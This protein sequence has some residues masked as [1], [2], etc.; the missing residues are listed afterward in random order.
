MIAPFHPLQLTLGL[1]VWSV[2]FVALY[3]GLSVACA[4]APPAATLGA[5]TWINGLLLLLTL[6]TTALLAYWAHGCWRAAG[7]EVGGQ[8][9]D[10][11]E[12]RDNRARLVERVGGV[13]RK[14]IG[15]AR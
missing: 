2:W 6:A 7:G 10:R 9:L 14:V 15:D 5:L 8:V 13:F 3:G 1:I 11:V 4:V 12:C